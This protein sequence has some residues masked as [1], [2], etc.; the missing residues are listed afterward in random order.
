MTL[1]ML[2]FPT[3][4]EPDDHRL[5]GFGP[6]ACGCRCRGRTRPKHVRRAIGAWLLL[7]GLARAGHA[8]PSPLMQS[9]QQ[10]L[11]NSPANPAH[12][13]PTT[14]PSPR[15]EI[16]GRFER[17]ACAPYVGPVEVQGL[18]RQLQ[19]GTVAQDR[20]SVTAMDG[21]TTT[22]TI[23]R[24]G[25]Y[26]DGSPRGYVR[27]TVLDERTGFRRTQQYSTGGAWVRVATKRPGS[28]RY[29]LLVQ[30]VLGRK[31]S[32]SREPGPR[33]ELGP[34]R[35]GPGCPPPGRSDARARKHSSEG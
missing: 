30:A 8:E 32:R 4:S 22:F 31:R 6:I 26:P 2:H 18:L 15:A 12:R 28:K 34:Q 13:P 3:S 35:H 25:Y 23:K 21:R 17:I 33:D 10:R 19:G 20:H 14:G 11:S 1:Q 27:S 7:L 24:T 16:V 9:V 5:G 29:A